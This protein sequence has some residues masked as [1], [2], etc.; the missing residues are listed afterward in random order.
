[1]STLQHSSS[2][3]IRGLS[4][5]AKN[6]AFAVHSENLQWL[7]SNIDSG[8]AAPIKAYISHFLSTG[9]P[10]G[11]ADSGDFIYFVDKN[12]KTLKNGVSAQYSLIVGMNQNKALREAIAAV[13]HGDDVHTTAQSL[14]GLTPKAPT[15]KK[16]TLSLVDKILTAIAADKLTP[17]ERVSLR[18]ALGQPITSSEAKPVTVNA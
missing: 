6:I 13:I 1:M 17:S 15:V 7:A 12:K 3:A 2:Y 16:P 11:F 18:E 9:K 14:A 8:H 4:K 5:I 10:L